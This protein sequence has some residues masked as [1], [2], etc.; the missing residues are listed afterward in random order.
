MASSRR[1]QVEED[2]F[3]RAHEDDSNDSSFHPGSYESETSSE[4]SSEDE[5]TS[6]QSSAE[7][8]SSEESSGQETLSG[9]EMARLANERGK[10]LK[11]LQKCK[12][13]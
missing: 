8:E 12:Q 10:I 11:I 7:E 1:R 3:E 5:G 9:S 4:E 2:E 13:D 6:R